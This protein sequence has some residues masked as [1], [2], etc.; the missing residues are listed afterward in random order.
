MEVLT[1]KSPII[2]IDNS[3]V[4]SNKINSQDSMTASQFKQVFTARTRRC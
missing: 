2:V 4:N 1:P 3:Q